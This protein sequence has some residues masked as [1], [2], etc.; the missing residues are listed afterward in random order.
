MLIATTH[1]N[2]VPF[3]MLLNITK[4]HAFKSASEKTIPFSLV[5]LVVH[6]FSQ[7]TAGMAIQLSTKINI[8]NK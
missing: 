8:S 4:K 3:S 1:C 7:L 2:P 5:V 6:I